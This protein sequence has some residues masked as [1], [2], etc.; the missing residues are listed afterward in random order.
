MSLNDYKCHC[1]AVDYHSLSSRL[2]VTTHRYRKK[3]VPADILE[4]AGC[5]WH[6]WKV[7]C[8]L[9]LK[10]EGH[11]CTIQICTSVVVDEWEEK[12]RN[13]K[14]RLIKGTVENKV[15]GGTVT[16]MA[17]S[18]MATRLVSISLWYAGGLSAHVCWEDAQYSRRQTNY[19]L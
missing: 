12:Q 10:P 9:E 13:G 8:Q 11:L 19:Q 17:A 14:A 18:P 16:L 4:Q 15:W 7:G 3:K 1:G 2:S 6:P 5:F